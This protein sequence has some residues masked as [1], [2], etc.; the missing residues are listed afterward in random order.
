MPYEA[1][2]PRP[3]VV[4]VAMHGPRLLPWLLCVLGGV[5]TAC[6]EKGPGEFVTADTP[7]G[8]DA[9]QLALLATVGTGDKDE[10]AAR[11]RDAIRA[12]AEFV[13]RLVALQRRD[14]A[15]NTWRRRAGRT[16]V[17]AGGLA[18]PEILR[19]FVD[20]RDEEAKR[21]YVLVRTMIPTAS[22]WIQDQLPIELQRDLT[23]EQ[24]RA[25]QEFEP[26]L[27]RKARLGA[28]DER[29]F[30]LLVVAALPPE[31]RTRESVPLLVDALMTEEPALM[32][33]AACALIGSAPVAEPAIER[34][35]R[36]LDEPEGDARDMALAIL[37]TL[38]AH[39]PAVGTAFAKRMARVE[40]KP[41]WGTLVHGLGAMGAN[42]KP[43]LPQIA[44]ALG[45]PRFTR[46]GRALEAL[47]AMGES[48]DTTLAEALS[49]AEDA[50]RL[51]ILEALE[52]HGP[53]AGP[54]LLAVLRELSAGQ[55]P[56][57]TSA[58]EAALEGA[59]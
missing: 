8:F 41:E 45:D 47:I 27:L 23:D 26:A 11:V 14:A 56:A 59:R 58:A 15:T 30:A 37:P 43:A 42:A 53:K 5:L 1:R 49:S 51:R 22:C 9:G 57:V 39:W 46:H 52:G 16:L 31:A 55:D 7:A 54:R 33:D 44:R 19:A 38:G 40:D 12:D 35:L 18:L 2:F 28:S 34:L 29:R 20:A 32:Q 6:G 48:G 10:E 21:Y 4:W 13:S 25:L 17:V 36:L 24:R 50:Q 3:Q